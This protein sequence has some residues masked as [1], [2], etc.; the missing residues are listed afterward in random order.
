MLRPPLRDGCCVA[1]RGEGIPEGVELQGERYTKI[2]R[3]PSPSTTFVLFI[4]VFPHYGSDLADNFP[5][6]SRYCHKDRMVQQ[7]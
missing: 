4:E 7:G 2:R 6:T 5:P 1:V 3:P